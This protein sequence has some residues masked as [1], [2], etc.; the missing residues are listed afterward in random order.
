MKQSCNYSEKVWAH[1]LS[2]DEFSSEEKELLKAHLNTCIECKSLSI[3]LN[4]WTSDVPEDNYFLFQKVIAKVT[5]SDRNYISRAKFALGF[6][7][8]IVL[9]IGISIGFI[10]KSTI[11]DKNSITNMFA[12]TQYN[13]S[14]NNYSNDT[15]Y[16][17][18]KSDETQS[19]LLSEIN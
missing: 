18:I 7:F 19:L 2:N 11:Y 16:S 15:F 13:Q 1:S 3:K 5:N 4:Q 8:G 17:E 12:D 10:V 6:A 14:L 9:F